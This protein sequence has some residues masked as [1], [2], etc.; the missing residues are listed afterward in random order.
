MAAPM[1]TLVLSVLTI[2]SSYVENV[3]T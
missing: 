1:F 3:G 2:E